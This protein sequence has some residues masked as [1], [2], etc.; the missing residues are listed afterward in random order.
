MAFGFVVDDDSAE[1][2]A[3]GGAG[4]FAL[5]LSER[6]SVS[7]HRAGCP[8]CRLL[9]E[10]LGCVGLIA[11][12]ISAAAERW[13]VDRLPEEIESLPG[14][15][16]RKAI[17]EFGYRGE[18]GKSL[19]AQRDLAAPEPFTRHFGPFFRRFTVSSEQLVEELLGAGDI[20]PAH[21]LACLIHF[22]AITVDGNVL[23]SLE[24]GRLYGELMER[25]GERSGRTRCTIA[26]DGEDE[27]VQAFQ[28]LLR[29]L[30]AAFVL[31]ATVKMFGES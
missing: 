8:S 31:D 13:L 9:D 23:L 25:P 10:E 29:A 30:W 28:R 12:P 7:G 14:F 21:A 5:A 20:A 11:T 15:L 22:G 16:L 3:A 2:R 19:R 4:A 6:P 27:S 1:K 24:E 18:F 17:E 26:A